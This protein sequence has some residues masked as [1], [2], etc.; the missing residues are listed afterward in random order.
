[1]HSVRDAE[2]PDT[3]E[4]W[5]AFVENMDQCRESFVGAV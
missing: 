2:L 1:M 5:G 4:I 3:G